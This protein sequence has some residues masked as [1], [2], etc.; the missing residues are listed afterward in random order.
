VQRIVEAPAHDLLTARQCA[1]WLNLSLSQ[2]RELVRAGEFP[3]AI[4]IGAR[5]GQRWLWSDAV[6]YVFM[7][8]AQRRGGGESAEGAPAG[9]RRSE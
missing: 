5:K 1:A 3:P 4:Q 8:S 9:R 6:G 7:R 2:F